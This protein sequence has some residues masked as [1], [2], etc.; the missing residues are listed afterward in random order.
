MNISRRALCGVAFLAAV[1]PLGLPAFAAPSAP[2]VRVGVLKFG[3]VN[4]ELDTIK[5][6]KFD[7][8]N[9]IEVEVVYFAGEDATNV[10]ML[11][12][13]LDVIVSD[14]LWVSRQRSEGEDLTLAPYS[15]AV[16]AIMV[17][18][19]APIRQIPD[20]IGKKIGVA[21]GSLDK[22]WLLIQGL[23]ERDHKID[24]AKESDVVFGAPPLL[25]EKA[26]SGELD[27]VLNFWHFCARLEANGFRRLIGADDAAK[28]LGASGPVSALG[29]VF[30][31][32]WA[33]EN[34]DAAMGFVKASADAKKLL[35]RSDDEWQRLA[36]IVRAEGRELEVLRDRYREGIPNRPLAEEESDAAKLYEVL[37]QLG[38]EKLVGEARQMAPGTFWAALK[39]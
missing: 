8:A 35:A 32:K 10:A 2:K 21:G 38:G 6:N 20:L 26:L 4:W 12:R 14:W 15:T 33:N 22:S 9:G 37:A 11:A 3:T 16:G 24:L 27:A 19:E 7:A 13:D 23:A 29:Y 30:R 25:S 1:S 28:A 5:H 17:K 18:N 39:T 36:P 34:P 31:D